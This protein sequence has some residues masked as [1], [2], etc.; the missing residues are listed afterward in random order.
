MDKEKLLE[1]SNVICKDCKERFR[2]NCMKCHVLDIKNELFLFS[3]G[4]KSNLNIYEFYFHKSGWNVSKSIIFVCD[5]KEKAEQML[6][7]YIEE[8]AELK[9]EVNM[10]YNHSKYGGSSDFYGWQKVHSE[11][12][13]EETL[14]SCFNG[15]INNIK[16]GLYIPPLKKGDGSSDHLWD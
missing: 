8:H 15:D 7:D 11:K 4:I 5:K 2:Y 13:F 1:S 10:I 12:L 3:K 9:E 6:A 14:N 16:E